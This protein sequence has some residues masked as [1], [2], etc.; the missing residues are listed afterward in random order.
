MIKNF[1]RDQFNIISKAIESVSIFFNIN[2][3]GLKGCKADDCYDYNLIKL[4]LLQW[5][6]GKIEIPVPPID[7][8]KIYWGFFTEDPTSIIQDAD[9]QF[10]RI[11]NNNSLNLDFTLDANDKYLVYKEP[12]AITEKNTWFNTSF[13]FG[14]IPDQ[15]FKAPLTIG[16]FR[17]YISRN[18]VF[19][20]NTDTK[21]DFITVTTPA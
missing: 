17:Y 13:N 18:P 5:Q 12:I 4:E 1:I 16:N 14:T 2:R 8:L 19:L 11:F 15:V 20:P 9:L 21:I 7:Q 10:N 3:Y 6:I